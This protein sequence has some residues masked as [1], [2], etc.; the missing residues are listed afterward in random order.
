MI[1]HSG[2]FAHKARHCLR[3]I[4]FTDLG[5]LP[6]NGSTFPMIHMRFSDGPCAQGVRALDLPY[7]PERTF[8]SLLWV[9]L[10]ERVRLLR[11]FPRF[12]W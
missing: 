10:M 1:F 3:F 12:V 9:E 5:G 6:A 8:L 4:S 11:P 7:S 2:K